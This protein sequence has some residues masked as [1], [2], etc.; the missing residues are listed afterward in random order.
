MP[1]PVVHV[2]AGYLFYRL[3]RDRLGVPAT[4]PLGRLLLAA[5]L[6]FLAMLPDLDAAL[7]LVLGDLGKYH[8]Q[9][10]HSLM[11]GAMW[12]V[13]VALVASL[14]GVRIAGR[15]F[16][17]AL[18]SYYAHLLFDYFTIGRGLKLLWPISGERFRAPFAVF[19]GLRWSEGLVSVNHFWTLFSEVG[20]VLV[21]AIAVHLARQYS[22]RGGFR[23]DN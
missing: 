5:A 21:A 22:E 19:Y 1:S 13:G 15:W 16:A 18:T 6:I 7:G 14:G 23:G 2:S 10:N 20:F 17:A 11:A 9:A 12:A 8:N 3:T 4:R